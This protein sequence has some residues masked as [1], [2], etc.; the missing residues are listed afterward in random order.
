MGDTRRFAERLNLIEMAPR[1]D[2]TSTGYALASPGEEYLVLQPD[3]DPFTVN[4]ESG[5][6]AVEWF[7]IDRRESV[8]D[9][10]SAVETSSGTSFSPP[11]QGSGPTVLY[12]KRIRG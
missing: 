1:D 4:L 12:L 10:E 2:L 11:P 7:D 8:A 6:Y 9:Q 3:G 5:T